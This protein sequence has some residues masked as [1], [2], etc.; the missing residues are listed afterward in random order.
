MEFES[1][2]LVLAG[3][4]LV[5][6]VLGA[7][8]QRSNYCLMGAVADFAIS[9][10]LRRMR[11]WML[12]IAVAVVAS[13]GLHLAGVV[14]L[15]ESFYRGPTL[16][17]LA[18]PIGGLMF[19]FGMVIACGCSSR[20]LVNFASGDLRAL[21][22]LLFMGIF[23]YATMRGL[24]AY[25]RLWLERAGSFDFGRLGVPGQGLPD[26]ISGGSAAGTLATTA[27]TLV[28][29]LP[30][31]A[32]ALCNAKFRRERRLLGASMIIGLCIPAG[33]LV[34]GVL[35][36]DDF[37]P[38]P[39]VSLRFVAPVGETLL[40]LMTWTGSSANFG[41]ATVVGVIAGACVMALARREF[42]WRAFEDMHD[43]GRYTVGGALMG[44]GGVLS[45]GCT[46]GQGLSG[47][48]TLSLGSFVALAGIIAGGVLGVR[49]LE[50]GSLLGAMRAA[51]GRV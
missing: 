26:L 12:T 29:A 30:L 35:G 31:L 8:I 42:R 23:G 13:Q 36:A 37:E 1:R 48:S 10:E 43:L 25:P 5:G 44:V 22:T 34:T 24:L 18:L 27:V 2:E 49:Y 14:D 9:G 17:W 11:A 47:V 7:T 20:S 39:L 45:L 21:I 3:G 6:A 33:W 40:Y 50:Q 16:A 32:F 19:G 4:L 51:L 46:V 28:V 41:I 15:S 38:V